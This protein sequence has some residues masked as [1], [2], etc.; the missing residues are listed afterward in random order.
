MI[1][2]II[3][4]EPKLYKYDNPVNPVAILTKA[5]KLAFC[6]YIYMNSFRASCNSI[7]SNFTNRWKSLTKLMLYLFNPES[8]VKITVVNTG[9]LKRVEN[10]R[11]WM[12]TSKGSD[13]NIFL[14]NFLLKII[15]MFLFLGAIS[16]LYKMPLS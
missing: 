15:I 12:Y 14:D 3:H 6:C 7:A 2:L 8:F 5:V 11:N 13:A 1:I 9:F 4:Y 10:T 16:P